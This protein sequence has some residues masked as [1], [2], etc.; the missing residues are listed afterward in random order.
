MFRT[1]VLCCLWLATDFG[2]NKKR[3]TASGSEYH[4]YNCTALCQTLMR[5]IISLQERNYVDKFIF[6][7]LSL[8]YNC[9]GTD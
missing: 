2:G 9:P 3:L 8:Q 5:N 7:L 1:V 4:A 6:S